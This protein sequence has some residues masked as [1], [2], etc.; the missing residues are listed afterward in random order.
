MM[1]PQQLKLA[2]LLKL[3]PARALD[4]NKGDFGHVLII[5]GDQ[6]MPGSVCMA[7]KAAL[8]VG[9]G[10]VT[11]ATHPIHAAQIFESTPLV[12]PVGRL[13]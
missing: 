3:L 12:E 7:G 1:K 13:F 11:V 10:R 2:E 6:G 8:R 5:G 4:A 9:A